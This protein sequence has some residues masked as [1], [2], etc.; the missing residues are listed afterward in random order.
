MEDIKR[1][2]K[3]TDAKL[4]RLY[5][6][7]EE[8]VIPLDGTLQ[9][10]VEKLREQR[11][12]L[13]REMGQVHQ[14]RELPMKQINEHQIEAFSSALTEKLLD[15]KSPFGKRYLHLLV[16]EIRVTGKVATVKGGWEALAHAIAGTKKGTLGEVPSFISEW[17]R[18]EDSNRR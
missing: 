15:P 6:A 10:R 5:A 17:R 13:L 14:K 11:E 12:S 9:Q 7:V 1:M 16:D 4:D 8:G 3:S 18:G 2:L